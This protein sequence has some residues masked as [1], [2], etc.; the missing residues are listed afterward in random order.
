[1]LLGGRPAD[2]A[3]DFVAWVTSLKEGSNELE[4]VKYFVFGCGHEDWVDTYQRI[5]RFID[6]K[7]E[8]AGANRIFEQGEANAAGD[9]VGDF[10]SWRESV[11]RKF[12]TPNQEKDRQE[13][14]VFDVEIVGGK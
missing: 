9:F 7:L 10:D 12:G 5:P 8:K 1:M 3:R 13:T 14:G 2:N 11:W 6:E 4:G